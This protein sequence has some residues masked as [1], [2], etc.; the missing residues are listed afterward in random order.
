MADSIAFVYRQLVGF[1]DQTPFSKQNSDKAL[2]LFS[3]VAKKHSL[4]VLICHFDWIENDLIK[5]AWVFEN[6]KWKRVFNQKVD[7]LYEKF[8]FRE[9]TRRIKEI[10][11]KNFNVVNKLKI[12][13][14]CRDKIATHKMFSNYMKP[15]YYFPVKN[16]DEIKRSLENI[17]GDLVV[18]KPRYGFAGREVSIAPNNEVL[19]GEILIRSLDEM[20]IEEFIDS[21]NG[22]KS[23]GINGVHD[24]RVIVVNNQMA[25][26]F[27][28]TPDSGLI[29]NVALGGTKTII[30]VEKL[31]KSVVWMVAGIDLKLKKFGL[32]VYTIDF[33]F[34]KEQNPWVVELNNQPD[35]EFDNE[36]SKNMKTKL[37]EVMCKQFKEYKVDE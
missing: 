9:E 18:L 3:E 12:E 20:F 6:L 26:S 34:D 29:S 37:F 21:S 25:V 36:K 19:V 24:L 14:V 8:G 22:I 28:R 1:E 32:R 23:L 5:K 30:N 2:E 10:L 16:L 11:S 7:L 4:K 35:F 31:P 17:A 27:V 15:Y 13:E 33:M